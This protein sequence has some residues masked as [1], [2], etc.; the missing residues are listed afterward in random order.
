MLRK[1]ITCLIA[2][3]AVALLVPATVL[4]SGSSA[5]DQQYVDPLAGSSPG[6]THSGGSSAPSPGSSAPASSSSSS[7]T[8]SAAS[9]PS[10]S[11]TTTTGTTT[12]S[13]SSTSQAT[14][15]NTL[16]VTGYDAPLAVLTGFGLLALGTC[17]RRASSR[18]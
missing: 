4:A 6:S 3:I 12:S 10:S 14:S 16:P 8:S 13:T 1:L 2:A 11:S 7:A 18:A 9:S 17:L 15:G 5:G